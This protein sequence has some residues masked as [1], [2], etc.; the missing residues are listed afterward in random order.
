MARRSP[1]SD[2]R[3]GSTVGRITV[4]EAAL[5]EIRGAIDE[6]FSGFGDLGGAKSIVINVGGATRM[7]SFG[8]RQWLN[9]STTLPAGV[10]LYLLGCPTFFVDQLNMVLNL[11]GRRGADGRR[12]VRVPGC[13]SEG[14]SSSTSSRSA[15]TSRRARSPEASAQVRHHARARREP[16]SSSLVNKYGGPTSARGRRAPREQTCTRPRRR[17]EKPRRSS[18]RSRSGHVLQIMGTLG[19]LFRARPFLVG[20]D[21]EVVLDLSEVERFDATAT[22]EWRRMLKALSTQTLS[23]SIVDVCDSLLQIAGDSLAMARNIV[24]ASL[25]VPYVCQSCSRIHSES[26]NLEQFVWPIEFGAKLCPTCA[27]TAVS[28]LTIDVLAP[29]QKRARMP[30]AT[31]RCS[32]GAPRPVARSPMRRSRRPVT[33]RPR[34]RP[35]RPDPRQVPRREALSA[36]AWP[37]CSSRGRRHRR[38]EKPVALKRIRQVLETR[39]QAIEL[40]S[41]RRNRQPL[42][43]RTS[44]RCSTSARSAVRSPGVEYVHGKDFARSSQADGERTT[45]PPPRRCTHPRVA[46]ALHYAYCRTISPASSSAGH[47]DVSPHNVLIGYDGTV[48]LL[49]FGVRCSSVT[50]HRTIVVGKWQYMSPE[51]TLNENVTTGRICSRSASCSI[52]CHRRDAVRLRRP[53]QIVRSVRAGRCTP[54]R[55]LAPAPMSRRARPCACSPRSPRIGPP[56]GSD[57]RRARRDRAR[58]RLRARPP[59]SPRSSSSSSPRPPRRTTRVAWREGA[60]ARLRLDASGSTPSYGALLPPIDA[61]ETFRRSGF[62]MVVPRTESIHPHHANDRAVAAHS[63]PPIPS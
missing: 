44:C 48:K 41:T 25:L 6:N 11:A 14:A 36:G 24:V 59:R 1:T 28:T 3:G 27:G 32:R 56:A 19:S 31:R 40:F 5:V 22:K 7:T 54:V 61:S 55:E 37:R 62:N 34:C 13:G 9:A 39:Q 42:C 16:E 58:P 21:G 8:V 12:A 10:D 53:K 2:T 45:M 15:R 57:R 63:V 4:G 35:R 33:R 46:L 20:V 47:R 26:A 18:T 51:I 30:P 38:L 23:V 60:R 52:C 29:L 43:T 17:A 50:A 49:D